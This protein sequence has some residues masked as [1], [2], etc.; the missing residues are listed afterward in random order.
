MKSGWLACAFWLVG[1]I[2]IVEQTEAQPPGLVTN[3][4]TKSEGGVWD[5]PAAWSAGILPASNQWVGITNAGAKTVEID[6]QTAQ[7]FPQSLSM[8]HLAVANTNTLFLNQV[9]ATVRIHSGT[10]IP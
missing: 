5:D 1:F 2:C 7:N 6:A 9:G 10:N 8:S 4:W 3:V